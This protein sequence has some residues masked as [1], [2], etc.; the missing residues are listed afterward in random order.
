[1]CGFAL[2]KLKQSLSGCGVICQLGDQLI[3]NLKLCSER[4]NGEYI[5]LG[6]SSDRLRE[7]F[8]L[9]TLNY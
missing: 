8:V 3:M 9:I 6:N 2:L 4:K 7:V 5:S 1:M